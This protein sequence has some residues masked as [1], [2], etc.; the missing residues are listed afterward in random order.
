MKKIF[1]AFG[2]LALLHSA[3]CFANAQSLLSIGS[4]LETGIKTDLRN[5]DV[6]DFTASS[7]VDRGS[8][9]FHLSC[10][11]QL[12]WLTVTT[13]ATAD[14]ARDFLRSELAKVDAT[15]Y[16]TI[17]LPNLGEEGYTF[18]NWDRSKPQLGTLD[19]RLANVL[20]G[21]TAPS[22][23]RARTVAQA[24]SNFMCAT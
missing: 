17:Q 13:Y 2:F 24:V 12:V 3:F 23:E 9:R 22:D 6:T 21:V 5:C 11:G 10:D 19:F 14:Q 16:Q 18:A 15:L 20:Y 4:K 1:Q 8:I 7:K